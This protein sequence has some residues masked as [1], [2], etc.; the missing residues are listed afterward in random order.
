[1]I[2]ANPSSS[3]VRT[4]TPTKLTASSDVLR[5]TE[6]STKRGVL[7]IRVRRTLAIPRA[8]VTVNSTSEIA[9][10]ARVINQNGLGVETAKAIDG[11]SAQEPPETTGAGLGVEAAGAGGWEGAFTGGPPFFVP[12]P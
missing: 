3:V 5:W 11:D 8:T 12:E 4:W 1:M 9:P 6:S 2:G 7:A 10:V